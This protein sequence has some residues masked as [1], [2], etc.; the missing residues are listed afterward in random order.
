MSILTIWR[1]QGRLLQQR[2]QMLLSH[3]VKITLT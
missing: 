1:A 2:L 3:A